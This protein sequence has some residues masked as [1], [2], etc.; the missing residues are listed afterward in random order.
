LEREWRRTLTNG[1]IATC[2]ITELELLYTA[3]SKADRDRQESLIREIFSWVVMPERVFEQ[4]SQV[5]AELTERGAHR[6][7]SPVDLL[8]AATANLHGF[9]LLHYDADFLRM[10][11]VTGQPTRWVADPG[12][13]D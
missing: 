5:Q 3:R 12:T 9:T 6:S 10:A 1:S 13:I 2:V 4:A 8:T 7:A 11:E